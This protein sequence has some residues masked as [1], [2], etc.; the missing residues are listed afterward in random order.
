MINDVK[1]LIEKEKELFEYE[2]E[3]RVIP[4]SE[5]KREIG[6]Q[7]GGS[8]FKVS[9]GIPQLDEYTDGFW[10]GEVV[11]ISGPTKQGKTTFAHTL[12]KNFEAEK[13]QSIWFSFEVPP[14]Q[15]FE[16]FAQAKEFYVPRK[17]KHKSLEWLS[18]RI[19]ESQLKYNTKAVF[20]DHLHYIVDMEK[21]RSNMSIEIGTVMRELHL[22]AV[23]LDV[24]IFLMAHMQKTKYDDMPTESDL[25]DSSFITQEADKTFIVW[26]ERKKLKKGGGFE[27]SGRTLIIVSN[28]RR[29]GTMGKYVPL[30]FEDN[31]LIPF[32]N[33]YSEAMKE[34]IEEVDREIPAEKGEIDVSKLDL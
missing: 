1:N 21:A 13:A 10:G 2:G 34:A 14:R 16:K 26:R 8:G 9:S 11:V 29:T 27:F 31:K 28:D 25:R 4:A 19:M 6:E 22:M 12:T 7:T 24:T 5:L 18:D 23:D 32:D 20:I 15:M 17:L 30:K 3:D 33:E